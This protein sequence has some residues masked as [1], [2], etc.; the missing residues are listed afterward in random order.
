M[1]KFPN[2]SVAVACLVA[3]VSFGSIF[4]LLSDARFDSTGSLDTALLNAED[5]PYHDDVWA[6]TAGTGSVPQDPLMLTSS[7]GTRSTSKNVGPSPTSSS[8]RISSRTRGRD[9]Y[10]DSA[11]EISARGIGHEKHNYA[12]TFIDKHIYPPWPGYSERARNTVD[13]DK[14]TEGELAARL[15]RAIDRHEKCRRHWPHLERLEAAQ[16]IRVRDAR[17]NLEVANRGI[18]R[19]RKELIDAENLVMAARQVSHP[20]MRINHIK[21]T[22]CER[23]PFRNIKCTSAKGATS[24]PSGRNT[25]PSIPTSSRI[26][27]R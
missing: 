15:S 26:A 17:N 27:Q 11:N 8:T 13:E 10:S 9:K 7:K 5:D 24:R 21:V 14:I 3:L 16:E 22:E 25:P 20:C 23:V 12:E 18:E 1:H 4:L 6:A 19:A 2:Y